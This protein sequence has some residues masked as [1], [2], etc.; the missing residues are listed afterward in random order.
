MVL[1]AVDEVARGRADLDEVGAVPG[2]AQRDGRLVEEDV[3]RRSGCTARPGRTPPAGRRAG[4]PGRSGAAS[5]SSGPARAGPATPSAPSR[6]SATTVARE[7]QV[8]RMTLTSSTGGRGVHPREETGDGRPR[9]RHRHEGRPVAAPHAARQLGLHDVPRRGG[10]STRA[11]L[12]GGLDPAALSPARDRGPARDAAGPRRLGAARRRRRAEARGRRARSRR[13]A[14][15]PTIPSAAGTGSRR[16]SGAASASTCRR[17]SR[18]SASRSSRTRRAT[19]GCGRCSGSR[20]LFGMDH[21]TE[22]ELAAGLP[23]ILESPAAAGTVELIVRR[24]AED[25]RE[26]LDEGDARS[27]ARPRR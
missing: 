2:P 19:T 11:R 24:P 20:R 25:E 26:V 15:R 3:R 18:R 10:R 27:R 14:A 5:S 13:G 22:D 9:D 8:I 21:R 23:R 1:V 7:A 6:T 17:C 12:P 16:A 4:R